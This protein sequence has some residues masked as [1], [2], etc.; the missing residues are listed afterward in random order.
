MAFDC[1][2]CSVQLVVRGLI[3]NKL[4]VMVLLLAA[5]QPSL[6]QVAS[7]A[8]PT[9]LGSGG[10]VGTADLP[11]DL[12]SGGGV[13]TADLPGPSTPIGGVGTQEISEDEIEPITPLPEQKKPL[14]NQNGYA[15]YYKKVGEGEWNKVGVKLNFWNRRDYEEL[16]GYG[17]EDQ[18]WF[19]DEGIAQQLALFQSVYACERGDGSG[20]ES[21][22]GD[23][24]SCG[25][26]IGGF[27][28]DFVVNDNGDYWASSV[29]QKVLGNGVTVKLPERKDGSGETTVYRYGAI[30]AGENVTEESVALIGLKGVVRTAGQIQSGDVRPVFVGGELQAK[31]KLA[32]DFLLLN[33]DSNTIN[34][35]GQSVEL[36]GVLSGPG[37]MIYKGKG[38][39][40]LSGTAAYA[41]DTVV[42]EGTLSLKASS[43][44]FGVASSSVDVQIGAK[45]QLEARD[46]S[47][48]AAFSVNSLSLRHDSRLNKLGGKASLSV[49]GKGLY[50]QGEVTIDVADLTDGGRIEEGLHLNPSSWSGEGTITK[51][52]SGVLTIGCERKSVSECSAIGFSGETS[53][54]YGGTIK[55]NQGNLALYRASLPDASIDVSSNTVLEVGLF[56]GGSFQDDGEAGSIAIGALSGDGRVII[57]TNDFEKDT[58]EFQVGSANR[59]S[60]FSGVISGLASGGEGSADFAKVGTGTLTLAGA[61]TYEGKTTI[62]DGVLALA[63]G[64]GIP[65]AS[66]TLVTGSGRLDLASNSLGGGEF[67]I[68]DLTVKEG[69]IVAVRWDQPLIAKSILLEANPAGT[70]NPGGLIATLASRSSPPIRMEDGGKGFEYQT[71]SLVLVAPQ[72]DSPEGVWQVIRGKVENQEALASKTYLRVKANG[73]DF[74]YQFSGLGEDNAQTGLSMSNYRGYLIGGS[75]NLKIEKLDG[76]DI[77]KNLDC[78]TDP[79]RDNC[80]GGGSIT[81]GA[82]GGSTTPDLSSDVGFPQP[83]PIELDELPGCDDAEELCQQL[84]DL[85]HPESGLIPSEGLPSTLPILNWGQ[86]AKLLGSGLTPRNIDAAGRGMQTYN[87]LLADTLFERLP[88]RQFSPVA[89]EAAVVDEEQVIEEV[90]AQEPVRGLWNKSGAVSD[91]AAQ[92]VLDQTIAQADASGAGSAELVESELKLLEFEGIRYAENPSLTAQYSERDG[93]RAWFRGFGGNSQAYS[94][95]ILRNDYALNTGGGV[96]GA[97]LSLSDS[98]Q[99]GVYANYGNVNV[100]QLGDTGGGSWSPDGWGGG[101][102]ADYWAEN[103]YVQG[104]LGATG[105]SGTQKRGILAITESLGDESATAEKSAT[106]IVGALRVGAPF[107][108]GGLYLEPQLTAT[109]TNNNESRFSEGGV[110]KALQLSYGSRSTNYLQTA[111][112]IKLAYPINSGDRAQWVPMV[113]VAW[114]S[115]WD[116]GNGDQSIGYSFTNRTVDIASDQ[117]NEN[118]A[119]IEAGLDYTIANLNAT[120]FKVYAKG[121]A[122]IWGGDRGTNWR[123]SGGVTFQF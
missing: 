98:V 120:S 29:S 94:S 66:P 39:T 75:L 61:N 18:P 64:S 84:P 63:N 37:G 41:G 97:D 80:A 79:S 115:D 83:E 62:R 22:V 57:D 10:G 40:T 67:R 101:I 48:G 21:E 49:K 44:T 12:G 28:G 30:A 19:G 38:V 107:Q 27:Y 89:V 119:L 7:T 56:K 59:D 8:L 90:P 93:W 43:D 2:R 78:L 85:V 53:Y 73:E 25:E 50:T 86:L 109:W 32:D 113:R 23:T 33:F 17:L 108:S 122:E 5:A 91:A 24:G 1:L 42:E 103:F 65:Q 45:L 88:L 71:G 69:G 55:V 100:N 102:T 20:G 13:G 117:S 81:P 72:A 14:P 82:G 31:G 74:D 3:K 121:G 15:Y 123:A 99:V 46:G 96:V 68:D 26:Q 4:L 116:T 92:Q 60:I 11:G 95:T 35:A 51:D 36:S 47:D 105:F 70:A 104:V 87:N 52:G 114:L 54:G 6:A 58:V 118:G 110:N 16:K 77:D 106:S 34:N 112:G 111:L 9:D 76:G